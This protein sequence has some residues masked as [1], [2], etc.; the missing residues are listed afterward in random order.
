MKKEMIIEKLDANEKRELKKLVG[1]VR[2]GVDAFMEAGKALSIIREKRLYRE[3]F[4][5][6]EDFCREE[7]KMS[8]IHASRLIGAFNVVKSLNEAKQ[9]P[10]SERV[11]RELASVPEEIRNKVW[12]RAQEMAGEGNEPDSKVVREAALEI[13][14]PEQRTHVDSLELLTNL[15]S[16]E[17]KLRAANQIVTQELDASPDTIS[18]SL[19]LLEDIGRTVRAIGKICREKREPLTPPSET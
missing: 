12:D 16:A 13:L 15:R 4:N 18:L 10:T 6:F 5:T 19:D 2:V 3:G 1:I 14:P 7:F 11:A 8:R 9:L 17:R